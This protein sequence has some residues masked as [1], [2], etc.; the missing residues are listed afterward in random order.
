MVELVGMNFLQYCL[1]QEGYFESHGICCLAVIMRASVTY[2]SLATGGSTA[3]THKVHVSVPV[4]G[5]R[6]TP[7]RLP[8][9]PA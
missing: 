3:Q 7:C 9:E 6:H 1:C 2:G 8:T 4:V 5:E